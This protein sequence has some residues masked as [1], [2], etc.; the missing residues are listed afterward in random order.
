MYVDRRDEDKTETNVHFPRAA[1]GLLWL[2][3]AFADI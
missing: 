3:S 2:Y 1:W